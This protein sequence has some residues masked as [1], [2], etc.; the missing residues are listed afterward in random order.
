MQIRMEKLKPNPKQRDNSDTQIRME[1]LKP[2]AKQW[3]AGAEN[4]QQTRSRN[5]N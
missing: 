1:K 4:G 5:R 3:D 2:N